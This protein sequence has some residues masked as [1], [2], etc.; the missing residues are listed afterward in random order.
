VIRLV[1]FNTAGC[2]DSTE[3]SVTFASKPTAAFSV[4]VNSQCL[5][6]NVFTFTNNSIGGATYKWSFGDGFTSS[7]TSPTKQYLSAGTY[8]VKLVVTNASGC[9]DS[10]SQTLN[11]YDKP[12]AAFTVIGNI[13]CNA[14]LNV[15]FN[16]TSTGAGNTYYWDFGDGSTSVAT[17]PSKT[18]AV[19]G[20]YVVKLVVTNS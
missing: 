14:N 15:G 9:K 19:A 12:V 17:N 10:A 13:N 2:K 20:L 7:A 11:I 16:N 3:R 4:N 18:F 6:G 8:V 5:N 1:A